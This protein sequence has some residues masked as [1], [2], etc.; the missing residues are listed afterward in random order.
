MNIIREMDH[1]DQRISTHRVGKYIIVKTERP[2]IARSVLR[3]IDDTLAPTN[4]QVET[5]IG[6]HMEE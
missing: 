4:S 6:F 5:A 1:E 3:Q 2:S